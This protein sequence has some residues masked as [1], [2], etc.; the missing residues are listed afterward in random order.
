MAQTKNGKPQ[1]PTKGSLARYAA[2]ELQRFIVRVF[3]SW[4]LLAFTYVVLQGECPEGK[5]FS[6]GV[7]DL[8]LTR[9][10]RVSKGSIQPHFRVTLRI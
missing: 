1:Q 3:F 2:Q 5:P 6:H 7:K 9:I 10:V 4:P 8:K